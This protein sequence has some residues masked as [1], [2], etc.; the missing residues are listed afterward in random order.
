MK[1]HTEVAA[2]IVDG[3]FDSPPAKFTP[4]R[5]GGKK[6]IAYNVTSVLRGND[7]LNDTYAEPEELVNRAYDE[8]DMLVANAQPKR[9][10]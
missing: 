10:D 3:H 7:V 8:L 6:S 4:R 9:L 2:F 5:S 1:S